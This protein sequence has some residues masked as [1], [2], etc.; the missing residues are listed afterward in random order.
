MTVG[1]EISATCCQH[2]GRKRQR[3]LSQQSLRAAQSQLSN[4]LLKEKRK[5]LEILEESHAFRPCD[6]DELIPKPQNM[7]INSMKDLTFSNGAALQKCG[8]DSSRIP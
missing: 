8:L 6:V 5:A 1:W 4:I 3:P 2:Q 7:G